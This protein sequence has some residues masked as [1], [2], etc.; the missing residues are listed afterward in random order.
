MFDSSVAALFDVNVCGSNGNC[1]NVTVSI[2]VEKNK[3]SDLDALGTH[4]ILLLL[5]S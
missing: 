2:A 1:D 5:N 4:F 3:N